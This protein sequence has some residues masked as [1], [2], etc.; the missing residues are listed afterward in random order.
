MSA[1]R[2]ALTGNLALLN[3]DMNFKILIDVELSDATSLQRLQQIE[4]RATT[5]IH[6]Q[7]QQRRKFS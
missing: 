3:Q 7:I 2:F 4:H 5:I 1:A 6:Y